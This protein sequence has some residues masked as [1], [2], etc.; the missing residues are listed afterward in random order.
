MAV[1]RTALMIFNSKK[2]KEKKFI[3]NR[4][5]GRLVK[6]PIFQTKLFT[7][8]STDTK[9]FKSCP[10]DSYYEKY[11][12]EK[13][14]EQISS[15]KKKSKAW[16]WIVFVVNL[17][18][19][20]YIFFNEFSGTSGTSITHLWE[21]NPRFWAMIV[22]LLITFA[23]NMF[24]EAT[25]MYSLIYKGS[26]RSRPFL[27]YKVM[28]VGRY[29]DNITPMTSGGQPFQIHYL[30]SRGLRADMSTTVP[31]VRQ[32]YWQ[33]TYLV[34][35][36]T[37]VIFNFPSMIAEIDSVMAALINT[38]AWVGLSANAVLLFAIV[39]LSKSK[40][41]ALSILSWGIKLLHKMKI[42][43]NYEKAKMKVTSF[44]ADYQQAMKNYTSD[45]MTSVSQIFLAVCSIL[46][47]ASFP[48]VIYWG[49][50]GILTT[51]VSYSYIDIISRLILCELAASF[52]PLPGG[53]G[54]AELSFVTLFGPVFGSEVVWA[55]L[56]W[57][58]FTY[59]LFILQGLGVYTY[60]LIIGNK[61]AKM[62]EKN[63]YWTKNFMMKVRKRKDPKSKK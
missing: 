14:K 16:K 27:S 17:G 4:K 5:V 56:L 57:R 32:I 6:S 52:M 46:V 20:A 59:F 34:I 26:K 37:V 63:G 28:A 21:N 36:L 48:Y 31:L 33:M 30:N 24:I 58:L 11:R 42:V 43:K 1:K 2:S 29:Y 62:L 3:K 13:A 45:W 15:Q 10:I 23:L 44:V 8:K 53:T 55:M 51:T 49:L 7:F 60:D 40:K 9:R 35:S 39:F 54:V 41:I 50:E 25:K 47:I 18:I 12:L 22:L 61:K 19:I 38:A